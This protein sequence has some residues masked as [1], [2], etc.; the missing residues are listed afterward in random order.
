MWCEEKMSENARP[1]LGGGAADDVLG[2]L[3]GRVRELQS[4]VASLQSDLDE[5][6]RRLATYEEFD[7]TIQEALTGA[8]RA[9]YE[10]RRRS[11]EAGTQ[12]LEQAREERRVLMKEVQRLR[13][14]RDALQEEI[15]KLRRGGI[16][17]VA[18]APEPTSAADLRAV[19]AEAMKSIFE[20]IVQEMRGRVAEQPRRVEARPEPKAEPE[21][22][23]EPKPAAARPASAP[24]LR[25]G[26]LQSPPPVAAA[27]APPAPSAP[28]RAVREEEDL[29]ASL[30]T[31]L[32]PPSAPQPPLLSTTP[33][34]TRAPTAPPP[35]AATAAGVGMPP[36]AP[37]RHAPP[38]VSV[39]RTI[40]APG[41]PERTAQEPAAPAT[42]LQL[43]L[44]PVPSFP[45]LVEIERRIQTLPD[46]RTLY[47]RDFRNGVATLA[48]GLRSAMTAEEFASALRALDAA[49]FQL[50][51]VG[52]NSIELRINGEAATA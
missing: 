19:A 3:S 22:R 34:V 20:D 6:Q 12:I 27:P 11:E 5:A 46:V 48:V 24:D 52:R 38:A 18:R 9:A 37:P 40:V 25:A 39:D 47:V 51:N 29:S 44:S 45:R 35:Q 28:K 26:T 30:A 42:E 4:K 13:E 16:A 50:E 43:V 41:A 2:A 14:E 36:V 49:R 33:P 7:E 1:R 32:A 21:P 17:P 23:A 8:L 10:I 31:R 15:A